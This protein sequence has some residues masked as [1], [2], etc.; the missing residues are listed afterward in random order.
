VPEYAPSATEDLRGIGDA[1][2]VAEVMAIIRDELRIPPGNGPLE[3]QI[4]LPPPAI[5]WWRRAVRLSWLSRFSS[6][7]LDDDVDEFRCQACDYVIL[8][9]R[10]VSDEQIKF[11]R[12]SSRTLVVIRIVRNDEIARGLHTL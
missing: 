10:I 6:Y 2:V 1:S 3:G 4:A 11:Q 8:Y 7:Y 5:V 12:A 9:R